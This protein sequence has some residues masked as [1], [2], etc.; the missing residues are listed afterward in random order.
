MKFLKFTYG[1]SFQDL[2][3]RH[4]ATPKKKSLEAPLTKT[5]TTDTAENLMFSYTGLCWG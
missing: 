4:L 3:W 2:Q 5:I 1:F